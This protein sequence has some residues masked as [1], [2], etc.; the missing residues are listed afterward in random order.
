[1]TGTMPAWSGRSR[2]RV[3]TTRGLCLAVTFLVMLMAAGFRATPGVF[4]KPYEAEFGWS[5]GLVGGGIS[6]SLLLYGP[7][8]PFAAALMER[9]GMRRVCCVALLLVARRVGPD[10]A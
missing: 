7:G 8:A 1:M 9:L 5:P 2:G 6:I 3:S 10:H 4:L